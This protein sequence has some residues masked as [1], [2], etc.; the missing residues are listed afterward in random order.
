[1]PKRSLVDE[2]VGE[3]MAKKRLVVDELQCHPIDGVL[4]CG[5]CWYCVQGQKGRFIVGTGRYVDITHGTGKAVTIAQASP[6]PFREEELAAPWLKRSVALGPNHGMGSRRVPWM[7][8]ALA[9]L[10]VLPP[11]YFVGAKQVGDWAYVDIDQAYPSIYSRL[12]LDVVWRPDPERPRL[13]VGC[14]AFQ[15]H[16]DLMAAARMQ[17][18]V[19]GMLR[20]TQMVQMV[21]GRIKTVSTVGWSKYLAPDL[22]GVI[23]WTLHSI[24]R[25]AIDEFGAVMWD[26]DGGVVPLDRADALRQAISDRWS[27]ATH[28]EHSGHGTIW[29]VKHWDIGEDATKQGGRRRVLPADDR[30]L[31]PSPAIL[32]CLQGAVA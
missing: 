4:G 30:V 10:D 17:R 20:S 15:T 21:H 19:G 28:L 1:M 29:G 6:D 27:L 3:V 8:A 2:L 7:R 12:T 24:A 5:K 18:A 25:M 23:Q 11:R 16:P 14:M 13:G 31:R 26:T 32:A 9:H 22:W